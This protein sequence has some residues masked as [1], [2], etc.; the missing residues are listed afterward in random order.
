MPQG[1]ANRIREHATGLV[2]QARREGRD[3][4][5][6]RAGDVH[7]ALGLRQAHRNVCQTLEGG[8]FPR[9]AGVNLV[10]L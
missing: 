4:I 3:R 9:E 5:T 8:I 10:D 7:K 1:D 6:I 2:E